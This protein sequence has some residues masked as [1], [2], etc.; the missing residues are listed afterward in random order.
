MAK[1][2]V[3]TDTN[4]GLSPE[5]GKELGISI[6]P[7]IFYVGENEY[8]EHI[9][10]SVSDFYKKEREGAEVHTSQA[11]MA[12]ILEVWD[13][14]LKEY[15]EIVHIP[16]SSSLSSSCSTAFSLASDYDG[17]VVVV[18]NQ[19]ISIT[20]M[21]SAITATQLAAAGK[22]ALQIKEILER[23]ALNCSIYITLETLDYLKKGG[24]ITPAAAALGNL[25]R[26][27]PVLQVQGQKLD[28]FAKTRSVKA[29]KNIMIS[30]IKKDIEERFGNDINNVDIWVVHSDCMEAAEEFKRE[31][32]ESI[33]GC[34]P[35][36]WELPSSIGGHVGP[37]CLAIGVS[38]KVN[39]ND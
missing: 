33:P 21:A 20:Q 37:G 3:V 29:G 36:I 27:K 5:K 17:R 2:A 19:R 16:M 23:E 30:A 25:L 11:S 6:V 35:D 28:A 39:V 8:L 34:D 32:M 18:D 7:M 12:T 4:S 13:G 1:V 22:S 31:V 9:D 10:M 15:D 38:A 14:L 24:R 26:L